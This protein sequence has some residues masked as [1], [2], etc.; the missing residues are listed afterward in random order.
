MYNKYLESDRGVFDDLYREI[1]KEPEEMKKKEVKPFSG[2][3]FD[4]RRLFNGLNINDM[5]IVPIVLLLIVLLDVD[6]NERMIII[7]LAFILGI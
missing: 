3:R 4:L 5:G 7:A 6:D 1:E 2:E